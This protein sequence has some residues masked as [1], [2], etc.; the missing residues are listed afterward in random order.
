MQLTSGGLS[1]YV[2]DFVLNDDQADQPHLLSLVGTRLALHGL[3]AKLMSFEQ[4]YLLVNGEAKR[5]RYFSGIE[6]GTYTRLNPALVHVFV[7]YKLDNVILCY[8]EADVERTL[9][10]FLKVNLP[11]PLHSSWTPWVRQ[12]LAGK[13]WLVKLA[14]RR[15]IAYKLSLDKDALMDDVRYALLRGEL[16]DPRRAPKETQ[17]AA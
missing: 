9:Y 7:E 4:A 11:L 6:A 17:R 15:L 8:R 16:P 14:S 3:R 10:Q 12:Y 1:A 13:G 5:V 2:H